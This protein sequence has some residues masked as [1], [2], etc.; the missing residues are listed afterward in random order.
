MIWINCLQCT[1]HCSI[2]VSNE[3]SLLVHLISRYRIPII[4][5]LYSQFMSNFFQSL[6]LIFNIAPVFVLPLFCLRGTLFVRIS[7]VKRV[8]AL[9]YHFLLL[10]AVRKI[11]RDEK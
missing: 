4:Q 10:F 6:L 2:I 8:V 3:W 7:V 1:T 9:P 11:K 5:I